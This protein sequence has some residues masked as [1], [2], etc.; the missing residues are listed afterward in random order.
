MLATTMQQGITPVRAQRLRE[1]LGVSER[2]L[3]RWREWWRSA[4][5]ESDFWK[6]AKAF[7]SPMVS[8]EGLPVSL[9]ERF[10]AD[11]EKSLA[12]LLRFLMPVSTPSGHIAD[13]RF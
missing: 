13:Q 5:V 11:E 10:G 12:D 6:V 8:E 2:T 7:V 9:L 4:F 1:L 3:A